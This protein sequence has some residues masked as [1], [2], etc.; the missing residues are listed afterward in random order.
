MENFDGAEVIDENHVMAGNTEFD[1]TSI[2]LNEYSTYIVRFYDLST[3][4]NPKEVIKDCQYAFCP[5]KLDIN[6]SYEDWEAR[7]TRLRDYVKEQNEMC[8]LHFVGIIDGER[9][10]EIDDYLCETGKIAV[11]ELDIYK[12]YQTVDAHGIYTSDFERGCIENVM[13]KVWWVE[14]RISEFKK[15]MGKEVPT[16]NLLREIEQRQQQK[17]QQRRNLQVNQKVTSEN[18][19]SVVEKNQE[20]MNYVILL[21]ASIAIISLAGYLALKRKTPKRQ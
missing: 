9:T 13:S 10:E 8:D 18:S 1:R 4:D 3:C 21:V 15:C 6:E 20:E 16:I 14:P 17:E 19:P 2:V 12:W 11:A 7:S 5:Y